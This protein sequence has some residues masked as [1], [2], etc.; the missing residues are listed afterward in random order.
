VVPPCK[1][2]VVHPRSGDE[3]RLAGR[4]ALAQVARTHPRA[5]RIAI[6]GTVASAA[7]FTL[8]IVLTLIAGPTWRI[9]IPIVFLV[10]TVVGAR[11]WAL[12][13]RWAREPPTPAPPPS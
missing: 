10:A 7:W 4:D 6:W 5:V 3:R 13:L 9:S 11:I 1:D 2:P 8:V 12:A